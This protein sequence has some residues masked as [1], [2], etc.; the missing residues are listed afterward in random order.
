MENYTPPLVQL[1]TIRTE[2]GFAAS[3]PDGGELFS[4]DSEPQEPYLSDIEI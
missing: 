1:I 2:I 4:L 3:Q